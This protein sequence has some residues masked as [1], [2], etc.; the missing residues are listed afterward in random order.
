MSRYSGRSSRNGGA[1]CTYPTRN[2]ATLGTV[3]TPRTRGRVAGSF[4]FR[5]AL[6]VA[7][8]VGPYLRFRPRKRPAYGL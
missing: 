5:P 8:E 7:T 2:F 1:S 4:L 3:V 6:C